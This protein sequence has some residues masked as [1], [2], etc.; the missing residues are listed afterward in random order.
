MEKMRLTSHIK[1][2]D[3]VAV[4]MQDQRVSKDRCNDIAEQLVTLEGSSVQ[5]VRLK[6]CW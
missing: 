3:I 5:V 6:K 4:Y 2:R 1:L